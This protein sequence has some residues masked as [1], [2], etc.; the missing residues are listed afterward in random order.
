M[1][2]LSPQYLLLR[3]RIVFG[4][5]V[6]AV[7][8]VSMGPSLGN[9]FAE[10]NSVAPQTAGTSVTEPYM[11]E[12]NR[13]A[14]T[15]NACAIKPLATAKGHCSSPV[16]HIRKALEGHSLTNELLAPLRC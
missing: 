9:E 10:N 7:L 13:V 16:R 2:S 1:N 6:L 14:R 3:L 12:L 15:R 5:L 4:N 11:G 8:L